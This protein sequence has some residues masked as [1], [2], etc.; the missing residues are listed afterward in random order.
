MD[1]QPGNITGQ[2]MRRFRQITI[3]SHGLDECNEAP[4]LDCDLLR[5]LVRRDLADEEARLVYELIH[6]F[7]SWDDAY[8][9]MLIA[10]Q[11]KNQVRDG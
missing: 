8:R 10:Q 4:E 7:K 1:N 3:S 2:Q 6:R 11:V 9:Q 5:M